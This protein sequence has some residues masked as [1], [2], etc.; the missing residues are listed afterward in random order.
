MLISVEK[1]YKSY[2]KGGIGTLVLFSETSERKH[3]VTA[4]TSSCRT[5]QSEP[6]KSRGSN[7]L[8]LTAPLDENVLRDAGLLRS[9]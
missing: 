6:P 1:K 5:W 9:S 3:S 8:G 2:K 7:F 4:E